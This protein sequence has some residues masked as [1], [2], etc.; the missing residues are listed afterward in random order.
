MVF[1]S[2]GAN[3]RATKRLLPCLSQYLFYKNGPT[4]FTFFLQKRGQLPNWTAFLSLTVQTGLIPLNFYHLFLD[5][6]QSFLI[7]C[8]SEQDGKARS[9]FHLKAKLYKRFFTPGTNRKEGT[10]LKAACYWQRTYSI[11]SSFSHPWLAGPI[12][13]YSFVCPEFP[14]IQLS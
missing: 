1:P 5:L 12:V 7:R 13:C 14:L 8:W 10:A 3:K 2:R 11:L 9:S 4:L 6:L